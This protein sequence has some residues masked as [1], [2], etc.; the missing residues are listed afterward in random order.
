MKN[1][2]HV[3]IGALLT[4]LC[5]S[6]PGYAQAD[7]GVPQKDE[8]KKEE[9]AATEYQTVKLTENL[10][11]TF[12][13][14]ESSRSPVRIGT[15]IFGPVFVT[16][17]GLVEWGY[18][19]G[20][21][22]K[23][24]PSDPWGARALDGT[25]D[26][27]G[28]AFGA[29]ATKRLATFLFRSTGDSRLKANL[30]G[31]AYSEMVTLL[32]EVGDGLSTRYGFDPWDVVGNNTGILLG[33]LLD[34]FPVLDRMFALQIEWVPTKTFRRK[35]EPFTENSD[36]FTDYSGQKMI[37]ATKLGG[38]PYV[39]RTPL[40]YVNLDLGYLSRGY[41]NNE[42]SHDTR[43]V[44]MGLSVNFS[45]AFGDLLPKGYISSTMQTVFN[46]YHVPFDLEAK[47]WQLS[48]VDHRYPN[49]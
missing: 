11:D 47:K 48:S 36:I 40:R 4:I 9:Q 18:F 14:D 22:F 13:F 43:E 35:F 6:M 29:Y 26:K 37:L 16:V 41:G 30:M 15:Y 17:W 23:V 44:Y 19:S 25:S 3:I 42:W 10:Y 46:Y 1:S 21:E 34:Q 33:L 28:H 24:A 20:Y 12:I 32:L 8:P 38:I 45:I 27:F 31:A 39:S 2:I 49:N 7:K 5:L